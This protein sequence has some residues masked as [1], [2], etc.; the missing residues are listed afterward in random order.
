MQA[1]IYAVID[2]IDAGLVAASH[3]ISDG[4]LAV[5][6]AEMTFE[7]E[8][9]LKVE[10]DSNLPL[11]Q[12]LFSET[13]GFLLEIISE[14]IEPAKQLLQKSNLTYQFIGTTTSTQRIRIQNAIDLDLTK[15]KE[16]WQNGLR[17]K[18]L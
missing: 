10:V 12:I 18:L 9:G 2:L 15:A 7:N 8:I 1:Q 13:G 6:L 3:D 5:A 17:E 11:T 16:R 14:N 4:G